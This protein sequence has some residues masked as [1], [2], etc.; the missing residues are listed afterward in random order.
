MGARRRHSYQEEITR[1]RQLINRIKGDV[2]E[3]DETQRA[4]IEDAVAVVRRHR[5]AHA[6]PLGMPTIRAA[7]PAP[8]TTTDSKATA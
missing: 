5:A 7:T 6:V 8:L 1:I 4:R 3:L 2:A